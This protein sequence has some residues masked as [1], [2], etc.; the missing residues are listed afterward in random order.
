MGRPLFEVFPDN[1]TNDK[2][3]GVLNLRSSLEFV[4]AQQVPLQMADHR[5]DIVNPQTGNFEFKVWSSSNTPVVNSEGIV[6]YI[7]HTTE[8]ITE[9]VKLQEE[10]NFSRE[11]LEK[12][13]SRFI[14]LANASSVV[15]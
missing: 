13:E 4:I 8:D 5:Y 15:I 6:Q 9:K 12:S 10:N 7:I 14:T 11:R 3:M 1:T 2:A